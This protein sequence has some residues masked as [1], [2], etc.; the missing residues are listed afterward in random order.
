MACRN[1]P[2][3]APGEWGPNATGSIWMKLIGKCS[4]HS[5]QMD[6]S[7]LPLNWV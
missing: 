7:Y 1:P 3:R 4:L 6:C 2:S 5:G